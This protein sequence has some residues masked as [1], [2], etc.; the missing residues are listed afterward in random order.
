MFH[1][2]TQLEC[3][4]ADCYGTDRFSGAVKTMHLEYAQ[5]AQ[6]KSGLCALAPGFD[7]YSQL[8]QNISS[9]KG[10]ES[11]KVAIAVS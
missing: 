2:V 9:H 3:G 1:D 8:M 4:N 5:F 7:K 6:E 10:A 11:P